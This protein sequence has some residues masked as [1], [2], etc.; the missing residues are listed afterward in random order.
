MSARTSSQVIETPFQFL[1]ISLED[2]VIVECRDR[3]VVRG[4]LHAYDEHSNL[5]IGNAEETITKIDTDETGQSTTSVV[6]HKTP[7]LFVRGDGVMIISN[8]FD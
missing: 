2:E 4:T 7:L 8:S 5:L 6:V 1:R 3:R